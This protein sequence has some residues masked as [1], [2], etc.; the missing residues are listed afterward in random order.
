[1]CVIDEIHRF[2][3]LQQDSFLPAVENG[4][5][6]LIG[7][8]TENPSF[9]VNDALLSRCTTLILK[10]L[11]DSN[12]AALA[13]RALSDQDVGVPF[14]DI[15]LERPDAL[16]LLL[17]VAQGDARKLL[18]CLERAASA[19]VQTDDKT[20]TKKIVEQVVRSTPQAGFSVE[21]HYGKYILTKRRKKQT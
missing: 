18:N 19:A 20:I 14:A 17:A 8:T 1:M 21:D 5:I 3:K 6:I 2:N 10:K 16:N 9:S 15:K 13:E 11:D 12:L 4:S 7:A